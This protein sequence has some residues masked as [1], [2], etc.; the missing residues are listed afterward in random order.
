[1]SASTVLEEARTF[2]GRWSQSPSFGL[3]ISASNPLDGMA[4]GAAR[5]QVQTWVKDFL[6]RFS[7]MRSSTWRG[8]NYD[9]RTWEQGL[10]QDEVQLFCTEATQWIDWTVQWAAPNGD[11]DLGRLGYEKMG[12]TYQ[13]KSEDFRQMNNFFAQGARTGDCQIVRD[14][15]RAMQSTVAFQNRPK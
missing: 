14:M 15:S 2:F 3:P 1:M 9:K 13:I 8:R 7:K 4:V 6:S 5:Q 12:N 11:W 10:S